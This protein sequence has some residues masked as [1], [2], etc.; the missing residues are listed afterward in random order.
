MYIR[1]RTIFTR[2]ISFWGYVTLAFSLSFFVVLIWLFQIFWGVIAVESSR[3]KRAMEKIFVRKWKTK[4]V[5]CS[6][7]YGLHNF[8]MSVKYRRMIIKVNWG[9]LLRQNNTRVSKGLCKVLRRLDIYKR[10][11]YDWQLT[12][13]TNIPDCR[14]QQLTKHY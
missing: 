10:T 8:E 11:K 6:K 1:W 9:N 14:S 2:S 7:P 3:R 13:L 12:L 5:S 4:E